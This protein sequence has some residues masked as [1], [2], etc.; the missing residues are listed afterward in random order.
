MNNENESSKSKIK[1]I[2]NFMSILGLKIGEKKVILEFD[3]GTGCKSF[4]NALFEK[5]SSKL[6]EQ[7]LDHKQQMFKMIHFVRNKRDIDPNTDLDKE[8]FDGDEFYLIP[9]IAGGAISFI[10][11]KN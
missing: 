8:L 3:E 2:V 1:I 10:N 4:L 7:L 6:P 9:P 5:Y 11:K